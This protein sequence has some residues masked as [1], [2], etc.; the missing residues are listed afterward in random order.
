MDKN[1]KIEYQAGA[2]LVD[3]GISFDVP[4]FF[5]KKITL[6]IKPLKPGTNVRISQK[7]LTLEDVDMENPTIQEF[8]QKG[9]NIKIIAGIIATAVINMELFKLWKYRFIKL[10]MLYKTEDM[11]Y[12][13]NYF[14][15]A[16]RQAGPVF[17][18]RIMESTPAMNFLMKKEEKKNQKVKP[19]EEKPSGEQSPLSEKP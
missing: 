14:L 16:Q 9:K 12:L 15:I 7:V 2:T 11:E 17:F 19:K 10:L 8:L 4:F 13:Y 18:Y 6:T 3:E 5:G 1:K